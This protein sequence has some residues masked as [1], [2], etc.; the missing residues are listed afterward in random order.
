MTIRGNSGVVADDWGIAKMATGIN[1]E[2]EREA[3]LFPQPNWTP[4]EI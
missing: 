4:P 3:R 2:W 1:N